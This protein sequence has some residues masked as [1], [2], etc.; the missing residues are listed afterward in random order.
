MTATAGSHK[1]KTALSDANDGSK[2]CWT[3]NTVRRMSKMMSTSTIPK[4]PARASLWCRERFNLASIPMGNTMMRIS[5]TII[6]AIHHQRSTK[7]GWLNIGLLQAL[8][9]RASDGWPHA[10]RRDKNMAQ[11]VMN[12]YAATN[13]QQIRKILDTL[14]TFQYVARKEAL[15]K[16]M[17]SQKRR[18]S[19]RSSLMPRSISLWVGGDSLKPSKAYWIS[20]P[21]WKTAT[22]QMKATAATPFKMS[23]HPHFWASFQRIQ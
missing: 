3:L 18:L 19:A 4:S 1:L 21:A 10:H 2:V 6:R 7:S 11:K 20:R 14:K 15:T 22:Q 12:V 13:H 8:K 23:S 16:N 9:L 17:V 5:P